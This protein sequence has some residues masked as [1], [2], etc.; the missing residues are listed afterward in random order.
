MGVVLLAVATGAAAPVRAA[1]AWSVTPTP[2]PRVARAAV[3]SSVS[4][5]SPRAC[6]AAGY[7]VDA[8]GA[9]VPLVERWNGTRWAIQPSPRLPGATSGFFFGVSCATPRSCTAVGSVTRDRDTVALAE[10]WAGARWAIQPVPPPPRRVRAA[11][12]T[13]YLAAVSCPSATDCVAV[14]YTGNVAGTAGATLTARRTRA[15]GWV[16]QAA[17]G[18]HGA[19]VAYYSGVSCASAARCTAVGAFLTRAGAG[20]TLAG[21]WTPA[22][23]RH[24]PTPTPLGATSVQLTGVSCPSPSFCTAVGYFDTAGID[25]MLA[26]RWDGTRWVIGRARY[27]P[28]ARAV[29][30]ADVS[31]PSPQSCTAVGFLNDIEGLD[32]PLAEHWTRRGWTVQTTP[33]I[34]STA[35]PADAELDGVSCWAPVR[36]IASGDVNPLNGIGG[37]LA[38]RYR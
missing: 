31:C 13:A 18:P 32:T 16:T 12:P 1:P 20:A 11:H 22:G 33:G 4:C 2:P 35:A 28:G 9:P 27:P 6:I 24:V 25:V 3:L 36:C 26:E 34:G 5:P 10:R 14:G 7:E 37:V 21:Q 15:G 8:A 19:R 17:S 29:R 23:W 38:E 30:F